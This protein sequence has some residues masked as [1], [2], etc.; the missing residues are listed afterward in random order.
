MKLTGNL[1][2]ATVVLVATLMA[3]AIG[4]SSEPEVIVKEV[5]VVVTATPV[6]APQPTYTPHPTNTPYPTVTPQSE[7]ALTP[8]PI[9]ISAT[10]VPTPTPKSNYYYVLVDQNT[11]N[12]DEWGSIEYFADFPIPGYDG[13]KTGGWSAGFK[14]TL[15]NHLLKGGAITS[16][17]RQAYNRGSTIKVSLRDFAIVLFRL[18]E[19]WGYVERGQDTL[20]DKDEV[21]AWCSRKTDK[22]FGLSPLALKYLLYYID[23]YMLDSEYGQTD[24]TADDS[25]VRISDGSLETVVTDDQGNTTRVTVDSVD[26]EDFLSYLLSQGKITIEQHD[27]YGNSGELTISLRDAV[28][29]LELA[30][31]D[32]GLYAGIDP[33]DVDYIRDELLP[34]FSFGD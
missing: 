21:I 29:V 19:S 23:E 1:R 30:G 31:T 7:A 15:L 13:A 16:E 4:C 18:C 2:W 12:P 28:D 26:V 27:A 5:Q 6:P 14:N 34:L 3:L 8:S 9:T 11:R 33:Q 32:K 20:F 22:E 10:A 24:Y 25:Y 17:Q